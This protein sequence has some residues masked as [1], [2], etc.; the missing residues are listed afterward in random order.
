MT[1]ELIKGVFSAM[2]YYTI[3]EGY[4]GGADEVDFLGTRAV[5]N[6][7][8]FRYKRKWGK[9]VS[10]SPI[11][12]GDSL[13][14][15]LRLSVPMRKFFSTNSFIARDGKDL[16]GKVFFDRG[17]VTTVDLEEIEKNVVTPGLRAVKVYSLLGFEKPARSWAE[18]RSSM[19]ELVDLAG[20]PDPASAFC[21]T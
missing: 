10:D 3:L 4:E 7:G 20:T 14:K 19:L 5:L 1:S 11:P 16:C 2:Y 8:L 15:P 9:F 6:D 21:K 13:L 17:P 18:A 12:R